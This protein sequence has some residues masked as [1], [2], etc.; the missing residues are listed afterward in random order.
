MNPL[1]LHTALPLALPLH[2]LAT[3]EIRHSGHG[4]AVCVCHSPEAGVGGAPATFCHLG[5]L[6]SGWRVKWLGTIFGLLAVMTVAMLATDL[7]DVDW[8]AY[9]AV[10]ALFLLLFYRLFGLPGIGEGGD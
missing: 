6:T 4:G 1:Q 5:G 8:A 2:A 10:S 7:L 3:R 9:V